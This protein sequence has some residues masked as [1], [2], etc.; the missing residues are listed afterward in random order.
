MKKLKVIVEIE[1]EYRD[2]DVMLNGKKVTDNLTI[3]YDEEDEST[4]YL[5][6]SVS[7]PA[8]CTWDLKIEY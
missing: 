2:T 3:E 8:T 4:H 1:I 5:D 6:D 7:Y